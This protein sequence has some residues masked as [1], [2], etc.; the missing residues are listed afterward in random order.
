[1]I[2]EQGADDGPVVLGATFAATHVGEDPFGSPSWTLYGTYR[3][4][5]IHQ[6]G[7]LRICGLHQTPTAGKGNR[8]IVR[9]AAGA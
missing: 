3:I 8:N 5:L 6:D 1:V 7:A 9:L 2:I 4:D